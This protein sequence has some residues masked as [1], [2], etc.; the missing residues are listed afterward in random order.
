[1]FQNLCG[2]KAMENVLLTTTQWSNVD[3]AEGQ[4][5]ED[6]LQEDGLWGELIRKGATLQRFHGT[7]E[8][9]FELI[10]KLMSNTEKPLDIQDQIVEQNMTLL[11]TNAGQCINEE[12]IAQEKKFKKQLDSLEKKLQE[13]MGAMG[14]EMENLME[15]QAKTRQKLREAEAEMKL[16]AGLHAAEVKRRK[17][18]EREEKARTCK[19]AAI[20][21]TAEDI[22]ITP[23]IRG[24]LTS[25]KTR[26]RLILDIGDWNFEEFEQDTFEITIDYK[27][28][29]LDGIRAITNPSKQ[30]FNPRIGEISFHGVHYR[31]KSGGSI[32]VAGQEF[33]IFNRV[34]SG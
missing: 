32:P 26:G 24:V 21:I 10:H 13:V 29:L 3:P 4:A 5:R 20:A 33:V 22:S 25:R 1:M 15:E 34:S 27:L 30:E 8:S 28:S 9:G 18:K 11:E 16:L 17:A 19:R 23:D 6:E 12:L 31:C 7:R 2:E 14:R